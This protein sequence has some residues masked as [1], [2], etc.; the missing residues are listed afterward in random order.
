M[1]CTS[2]STSTLEAATVHTIRHC[3]GQQSQVLL[4]RP[5]LSSCQS[6]GAALLQHV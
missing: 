4:S 2:L 6:S 3:L 5:P 1:T